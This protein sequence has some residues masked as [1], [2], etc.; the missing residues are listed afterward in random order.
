MVDA[1]VT[2]EQESERLPLLSDE[3]FNAVTA[4]S[5]PTAVTNY[6]RGRYQTKWLDGAERPVDIKPFHDGFH[7]AAGQGDQARSVHSYAAKEAY[8]E[9]HCL[10]SYPVTEPSDQVVGY[11][12]RLGQGEKGVYAGPAFL[13][14]A[15]HSQLEI[16]R[17]LH[18]SAFENWNG[19]LDADTV[20]EMVSATALELGLRVEVP[21]KSHALK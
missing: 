14:Q 8:Q 10:H 9:N 19:G 13:I 20:I 6:F 18:E 12:L 4:S 16:V 1:A 21:P 2:K 11:V 7:S 3:A 15:G 17:A 5:S